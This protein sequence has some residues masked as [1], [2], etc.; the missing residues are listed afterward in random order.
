MTTNSSQY[1]SNGMSHR[2]SFVSLAEEITAMN[3]N[4]VEIVTKLNQIVTSQDSSVSISLIDSMGNKTDYYMPTVG[5]LKKEIDKLNTNVKRLAGIE[6]TTNVIDGKIVKKVYTTDI[7]KEPYPIDEL[8]LIERFEPVNNSFFESLMNP[9]LAVELD[10]S[11]KVNQD[12]NKIKARRYIVKFERNSDF[13]LT[14]NGRK[15]YNSFKNNFENRKDITITEFNDWYNEQLDVGIMQ[16]VV[17]PYDEEIFDLSVNEVNYHG[18]FSVIKTETDTLNKKMWYH[19]NTL[20]YF[21]KDGYD[22]SLSIGD[23]LTLN[24]INSSSRWVVKEVNTESSN[25][26]VS[27]ERVEGYDPVP[28]GT[29]VLS[30][31]SDTT[32]QKK[33]KIT[34]G[35]DE[36]CVLFIKPINTENNV[37]STLWSKGTYFYTNDLVLKT[38]DNTDLAEYYLRSVYD[39]GKTLKDIVLRKIPTEYGESPNRVTLDSNDFKVVQIN[40]HLTDSEN[41]RVLKNL[42][43]QKIMSKS[44]IS[45]INSA[46]IERNREINTGTYGTTTELN[47]AKNELNKLIDNLDIETKRLSST[48]SQISAKTK[49]NTEYS[50]FRVRGFWE[51][52]EPLYNGKTSPQHIVQFRIQ[53]RYSSKTGEIN[54]TEGFKLRHKLNTETADNQ[55]RI[56]IDYDD[57]G[58]I[59]RLDGSSSTPPAGS[60]SP[61]LNANLR[62]SNASND[63]TST[64]GVGEDKTAYFS[65]WVEILTDVRKRYWDNE[66]GYWYWKLEDVENA[67]KPNINQLDIPIK[68]NERVDIRIKSISEV[69]WPDVKFESEWSDILSIEFP[70]ELDNIINRNENILKEASQDETLVYIQDDL[71]SRGVFKHIQNSFYINESYYAH[72]DKDLQSSFRDDNG[73]YINVFEYLKLLSE[74]I[75]ILEEQIKNSKGIFTAY[76]HGPNGIIPIENN[77]SYDMIVELEDFAIQSGTTRSYY[78]YVSYI[79]D[80][81]MEIKNESPSVPLSLLSNRKYEETIYNTFYQFEDHKPLIV[82]NKNS[83]Y[84]QFDYQYIWFSDNSNGEPIYSGITNGSDAPSVLSSS[85]YNIG[86]SGETSESY[87]NSKFD[88]INDIEWEGSGTTTELFATVHPFSYF[89]QN[90]VETGSNKIRNVPGNSTIKIPFTIFYKLDGN[91]SKNDIYHVPISNTPD[92]RYRKVKVY[93]ETDTLI[94]PFEFEINFNIKQY[95]EIFHG[96]DSTSSSFNGSPAS[97]L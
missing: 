82:D 91:S 33:V 29:H 55:G 41:N 34:V 66:R 26:R 13:S 39:C 18:L 61:L 42:H 1:N 16:N 22:R 89:T 12:V 69:G 79:Q 87:Y 62:T 86:W 28:I 72:T 60:A 97:T 88:I 56:V 36:F 76:L 5:Y 11:D 92:I 74:K 58:D 21:T 90:L 38:D 63:S 17:K 96:G 23:Y 10:I 30:Y 7:N 2:S 24:R 95:R 71:N 32:K 81:Y 43:S 47:A 48:V 85:I 4:T 25:Y 8:E 68:P 93:L 78:N 67:D 51:I 40:K 65:N 70:D 9:L 50:K 84:T 64:D 57:M 83:M 52:P 46:I 54:P 49:E 35:F 80:Y 77:N 15:S 37:I 20:N 3:K 27:L 44:K 53:Y 45:Q 19:L 59:N 14:I 94:K 73:N 6:S 75:N 31:Y